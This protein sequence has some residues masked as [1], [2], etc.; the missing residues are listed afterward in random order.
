MRKPSLAILFVTVFI[1]LVG[2]GIVVPFLAF[3]VE[4]FGARASTVGL[5]M[6][7]YSAAQFLFAPIWG[8]LSDRV[9][10]KPILLVGLCGSVIGF[11][12]F[13]FAHSLVALFVGRALMGIFGATIS[14][15]QAAV[16]DL[17]T[18]ANRA[19]GMGVIG[20]AIGLGFIFGPS[21][22]GML[23]PLS[24]PLG[25]ALG[26]HG[27]L[28]LENPYALPSLAAALLALVNLCAAA[29]FLPESLPPNLEVRARES[30][31]AQLRRGLVN[32]S[33]R[34][35]VLILFLF[36]LGFGGMEATLT[37]LIERR[38][39]VVSQ[40]LL[41]RHV[42]YLFAFIGVVMVGF[43]GGL[44]GP[45]ARRF[46]EERL[47]FGGL[48]SAAISLACLPIA[49]SWPVLY[50]CAFGLAAGAGLCNP[51]VTSLISR[52]ARANEQG[53]TLGNSQ[54]A[55]S[56]ARV[57]G[58]FLAGVLFQHLSPGAPYAAGAALA[59]AAAVLASRLQT[60]RTEVVEVR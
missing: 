24:L 59:L 52:A 30:R 13:G 10:R 19:K 49:G 18:P 39:G 17:T 7:S 25:H 20:A 16:A 33:L 37:L 14:T 48:L 8:R 29:L 46:G 55:A 2:F 53:G 11:T 57:L 58:P 41:V 50:L 31:L 40:A 38:F 51:S 56:L 15:A 36:T 47:L 21:L 42:S 28:F 5:L 34:A 43:Q 44:V 22:S 54:A 45:L 26:A 27:T 1:D 60:A 12:L 23:A 9:G 35:L 4:S 6:S 32:P 3:Y